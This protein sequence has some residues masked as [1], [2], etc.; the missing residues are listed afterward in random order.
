MKEEVKVPSPGESITEVQ[1]IRFMFEN[2]QYVEKDAPIAEVDSDKATLSIFATAS[3]SI[4]LM[5]NEGDTL[6]VGAILAII[7]T[8]AE[9][10]ERSEIKPETKETMPVKETKAATLSERDVIIT[11]QARKVMDEFQVS[12]DA[13]LTQGKQR[14]RSKDI[15]AALEQAPDL[16]KAPHAFSRE[17][18]RR[19]LS[20]LRLKLSERLVSVK[21]QTAMLT[22]F[23]IIN[24]SAVIEIKKK[25]I[26]AFKEKHGAS[27]GFM[28]FFTKACSQALR[29]YPEVNSYIDGNELVIPSYTDISIAVSTPKGLMVP[30][31]RN[32]ESLSIPELELKIKE[33]AGKTRDKSIT[34]EE[35]TGGTFTIT[36]GG[37]FGSLF[38]TPILNPPQS[39]ILGMH[40]I[41][42]QVVAVN[43]EIKIQPM[44]YV[45]LS[46]DHRVIDGRDS[47]GF[48][49]KVKELIENPYG[50][51][52]EGKNP[53]NI[54]LDLE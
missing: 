33:L 2:G 44:M 4:E 21:N 6:K 34:L 40:N 20:M 46:Y 24:M 35:M 29:L 13:L 25:Y 36:N 18:E 8:T 28:S 11:P 17:V 15:K 10:P 30:V 51:L 16:P 52:F 31:I 27:F 50:M 43:G 12:K 39:G 48:L 45:A 14:V 1:L 41:V 38:S 23:N 47:V 32:A 5:C 7:D 22:T 3:G 19:K 37:V 53:V 42:D 54:L 49:L 26:E 9:K